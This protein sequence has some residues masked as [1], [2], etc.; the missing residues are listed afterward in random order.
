MKRA[1]VLMLNDY[2]HAVYLDE[3]EAKTARDV[4]AQKAAAQPMMFYHI[5]DVP[6]VALV[7]AVK[8]AGGK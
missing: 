1:W 7:E 8:T 4:L 5:C 2:P 6:L 3:E